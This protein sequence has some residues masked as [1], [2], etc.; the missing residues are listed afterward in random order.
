[1]KAANSSETLATIY[2]TTRYHNPE[3]HTLKPIK[4]INNRD[5]TVTLHRDIN[6]AA[7]RK[8]LNKSYTSKQAEYAAHI[9]IF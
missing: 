8:V 6:C 4:L 9:S 1:M 7:F 3:D 5:R 2:E